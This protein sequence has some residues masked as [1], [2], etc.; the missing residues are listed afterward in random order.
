MTI[1]SIPSW[2]SRSLYNR[3]HMPYNKHLRR[4]IMCII[5]IMSDML[6]NKNPITLALISM[7]TCAMQFAFHAVITMYSIGI[8]YFQ[9]FML[10]DK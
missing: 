3:F 6:V 4:P 1:L 10:K 8:E 5:M 2:L 7:K 9:Q